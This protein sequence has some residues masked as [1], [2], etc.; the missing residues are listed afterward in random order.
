M[1]SEQNIHV[2]EVTTSCVG[3]VQ[4]RLFMLQRKMLCYESIENRFSVVL[5]SIQNLL[6]KGFAR[7]LNKYTKSI[8]SKSLSLSLYII[9]RRAV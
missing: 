6:L 8:A 5:F 4:H 3:T 9:K 2:I 1:S 7:H